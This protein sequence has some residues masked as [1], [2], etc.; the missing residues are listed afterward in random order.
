[1]ILY[2]KDNLILF[3]KWSNVEPDSVSQEWLYNGLR[4]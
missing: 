3:K 1:M 2:E 4:F